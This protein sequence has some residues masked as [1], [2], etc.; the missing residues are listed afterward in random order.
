MDQ[1]WKIPSASQETICLNHDNSLFSKFL[2]SLVVF[3]LL[4]MITGVYAQPNTPSLDRTVP[5]PDGPTITY[6]RIAEIT[7]D[8]VH[9]RSGP[10]TNYYSCG[11]VNNKD[12][13][14][15][16]GEQSGWA[17]IIPPP[18]SFSWISMQYVVVSTS[19]PSMGVVTGDDIGVYAGCDT[20]L[21]M[22]STSKQVT[23]KRGSRIQLLG[24]EKDG[25][26]KIVPPKGSFLWVS[27]KYISPVEV[28]A[29]SVMPEEQ[30][31]G[32]RPEVTPPNPSELQQLN[33][34]YTLQKQVQAEVAKPLEQQDYTA[35]K[36]SLMDIRNNKG[37]GKAVRYAE[38]LLNRIEGYELAQKVTREIK[39]QDKSL[40]TITSRIHKSLAQRLSEITDLGRYAVIGKLE[41][42]TVY[43]EAAQ[44]TRYRIISKEG[45][46]RCY[47]QAAGPMIHKDMSPFVGKQVGLIGTITAHAPINHALVEFTDIVVLE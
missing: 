24:Q 30:P 25:Y 18:G 26:F 45:T 38:Y 29:A 31:S 14:S 23:L 3:T 4:G 1:A 8:D 35:I 32:D 15:V 7:G 11:K 17:Q 40:E 5:K 22:H 20:V 42:S 33:L 41:R 16:V 28:A 2:W 43:S 46:I 19:D 47:A 27:G 34:Y 13:V 39:Q 9:V 37:A 10:G 21:P 6:P 36:K 12:T 44:V